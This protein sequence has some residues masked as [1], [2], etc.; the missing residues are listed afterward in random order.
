M[1]VYVTEDL[2]DNPPVV[3]YSHA[4]IVGVDVGIKTFA[5]FSNGEKIEHP[6][7]LKIF[8]AEIKMFAEKSFRGRL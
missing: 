2:T 1:L 7:V 6:K 5:A 3:E 4:T 8:F